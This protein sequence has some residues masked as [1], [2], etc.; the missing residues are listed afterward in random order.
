MKCPVCSGL[1]PI[2]EKITP[3]DYQNN[4]DNFLD[5]NSIDVN[6]I[7]SYIKFPPNLL[8]LIQKK[9]FFN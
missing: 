9:T 2:C 5:F 6:L 8:I 3:N 4:S 1:M 7:L